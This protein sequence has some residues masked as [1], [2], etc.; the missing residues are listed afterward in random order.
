MVDNG[1]KEDPIVSSSKKG[2]AFLKRSQGPSLIGLKSLK[3]WL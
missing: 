1:E 3:K 2:R